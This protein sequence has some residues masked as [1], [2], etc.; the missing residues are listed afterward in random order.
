MWK[1]D[2]QWSKEKG[3]CIL[4]AKNVYSLNNLREYTKGKTMLFATAVNT[5]MGLRLPELK[6]NPNLH[7]KRITRTVIWNNLPMINNEQSKKKN[8]F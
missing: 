3:K 4:K 2:H 5:Y 8:K 6:E 7:N 1:K